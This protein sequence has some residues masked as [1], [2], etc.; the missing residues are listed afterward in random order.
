MAVG[1]RKKK[2]LKYGLI[3]A[4]LFVLGWGL[5][6]VVPFLVPLGPGSAPHL[7][8]AGVLIPCTYGSIDYPELQSYVVLRPPNESVGYEFRGPISF[9]SAAPRT[10]SLVPETLGFLE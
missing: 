7:A 6:I 9:S 10:G 3:L 1:H 5:A 2:V 4:A 8:L